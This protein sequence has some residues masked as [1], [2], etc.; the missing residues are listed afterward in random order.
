MSFLQI[1][2]E[3]RKRRCDAPAIFADPPF[4]DALDRNGVEIVQF[5]PSNATHHHEMRLFEY[6]QVLHHPEPGHV[7]E[8]CRQVRQRLSVVLEQ[9]IQD[10]ATTRIGKRLK[11]IQ[12]PDYM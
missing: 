3:F 7:R 12:Q 8:T 9:R 10:D 2:R 11:D 6:P 4:V 5:V 1:T